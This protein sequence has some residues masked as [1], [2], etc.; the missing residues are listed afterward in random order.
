MKFIGRLPVEPA[1]FRKKTCPWNGAVPIG[2]APRMVNWLKLTPAGS[3]FVKSTTTPAGVVACRTFGSIRKT[4]FG[5]RKTPTSFLISSVVKLDV[6]G[7]RADRAAR[8]SVPR[9]SR[10]E[11]GGPE[12]IL[13][14]F[15]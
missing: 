9:L 14:M 7:C 15:V 5:V 8:L 12:L 1:G 13:T 3:G 6:A 11:T 10:I 4:P 2:L